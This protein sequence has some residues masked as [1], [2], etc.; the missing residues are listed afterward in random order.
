[1]SDHYDNS[2][3]L[4]KN[5]YQILTI[6][7]LIA[8]VTVADFVAFW[9]SADFISHAFFQQSTN[10]SE[11]YALLAALF[12]SGYL[13]RPIGG[14]FIGRYGDKNGRKAA[15]RL[16]L[17]GVSIFTLTIAFL[18]TYT[19]IGGLA[20]GL[21]VLARLGQGFAFGGQLPSLWVYAC[22]RLPIGSIGLSCGLISSAMLTSSLILI[23][24]FHLLENLLSITDWLVFGWRIAFLAS[25]LLSLVL[26]FFTKKLDETPI[27]LTHKHSLENDSPSTQN[28]TNPQHHPSLDKIKK[29]RWTGIVP[30]LILSL[31][32]ANVTV[33]FIFLLPDLIKQT[34]FIQETFVDIAYI[35]C[36]VFFALG[37]VFF[38]FLTDHINAG[39]VLIIGLLLFISSAIWTFY[40]LD[41]GG[42]LMFFSMG[43]LGFFSGVTGAMPTVMTRLC[44][45]PNRLRTVATG[46]NSVYALTGIFMPPLLGFLS[47]HADFAPILYLS[48]IALLCIFLS[49]YVH[50]NPKNANQLY[51]LGD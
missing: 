24:L 42:S 9:Y 50:E 23:G 43:V 51:N 47:Y 21:F 25:G 4:Q 3:T 31:F 6:C 38:G 35:I 39:K 33:V 37:T 36:L 32:I 5:H 45:V 30:V 34:F 26:L 1:M 7:S 14:F 20:A 46:Y 28:S 44:P 18:P 16:S 48:F 11:R 49:L 19:H 8:I 12:A 22:E 29:N 41:T 13:A 27:F 2:P 15:L 17:L 40:D 10:N